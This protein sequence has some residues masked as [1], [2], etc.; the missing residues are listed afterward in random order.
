MEH[1]IEIIYSGELRT[2]STHLKS[3]DDIITDAPLDNKGK[4]EALDITADSIENALLTTDWLL[5]N[6]PPKSK[7]HY[8]LLGYCKPINQ[9]ALDK[10]TWAI[11]TGERTTRHIFN[12]LDS[13]RAQLGHI[14]ET[15]WYKKGPEICCS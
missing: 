4:G 11:A 6:L 9:D 3:G 1:Q 10:L 13:R 14:A 12:S 15:E 2:W 5:G 7:I 8:R